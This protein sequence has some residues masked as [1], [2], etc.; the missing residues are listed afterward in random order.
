MLARSFIAKLDQPAGR[1]AVEQALR[2]A[3]ACGAV[4]AFIWAGA[5][6]LGIVRTVAASPRHDAA[7]WASR[8]VSVSDESVQRRSAAD[9]LFTPRER[10][11]LRGL[12]K[13]QSTKLIARELVLSPE[14][15][16]HHLKAIF[17]KLGVRSRDDVVAEVR[18]R[19]LV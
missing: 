11:V 15:I 13:G 4:Q 3:A 2:I 6:V 10:D 9:M 18:R 14:T 5:E 1:L 19:A 17:S 7:A 16:K 8:I 12:V